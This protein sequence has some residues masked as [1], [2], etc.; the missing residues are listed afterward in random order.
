MDE[1]LLKKMDEMAKL[2][3]KRNVMRLKE[4][5]GHIAEKAYLRGDRKLVDLIIVSYSLA[6]FF[7]KHYIYGSKNWGAFYG[8]FLSLVQSAKDE[9]KREDMQ[10]FYSITGSMIEEIGRMSESTG[11]FQSSVID[12]ARIKAGTQIYAHGASL[13]TAA[14]FAEVDKSALASYINVTKLPDKYGTMSVKERLKM[15]EEL[16]EK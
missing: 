15:A 14:S 13:A 6:K 3:Q 8:R 9:L 16:F 4:L 2:C 1:F 11:R 10:A 7:E 5:G 12:K